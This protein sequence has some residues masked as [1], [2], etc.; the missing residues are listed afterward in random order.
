M[1]GGDARR[2]ITRGVGATAAVHTAI[3]IEGHE[4]VRVT[5]GEKK[6]VKSALMNEEV[7]RA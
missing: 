2:D 1:L 4:K 5:D 7:M 3:R 6:R